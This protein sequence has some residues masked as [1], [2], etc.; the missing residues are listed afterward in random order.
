MQK[1]TKLEGH[2]TKEDQRDRET[3]RWLWQKKQKERWRVLTKSRT[4]PDPSE[5]SGA[6]LRECGGKW[7]GVWNQNNSR[8][9]L[10]RPLFKRVR[11]RAFSRCHFWHPKNFEVLLCIKQNKMVNDV[12]FIN[13]AHCYL[14]KIMK[15]I[16]PEGAWQTWGCVWIGCIVYI[17][18]V[19]NY[20]VEITITI[21]MRFQKPH[22]NWFNYNFQN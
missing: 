1:T 2:L 17:Y 3:K 4:F 19:H 21:H 13:A 7:K 9:A 10:W 20:I 14:T 8:R 12:F 18:D 6:T 16:F 15:D 5:E 11:N 22:I